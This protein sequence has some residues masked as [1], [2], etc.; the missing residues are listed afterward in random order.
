MDSALDLKNL[1]AVLY[2][3]ITAPAGVDDG[4]ATEKTLPP[5]GL[6]AIIVGDDRLSAR[7]RVEIYAN[8]YFYR[9][10]DAFKEDFPATLAV[11]GE[12]DFHNLVTGYLIDHPP[13][14][15]EIQHAG[16][17]LPDFI[18]TRPLSERW[19][20]IADLAHL[21][22]AMIEVFHAPD[23]EPLDAAMMRMVA[24]EEWG[25]IRLRTHPSLRILDLGWRADMVRRVVES[26]E[27]WKEPERGAVVILVWRRGSQVHYRELERGESAA[28]ALAQ[29]GATFAAMCDAIAA[30]AGDE[31]ENGPALISRLLDR[32]LGD[33]VLVRGN[34]WPAPPDAAS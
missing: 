29:S 27:P 14:E 10:L 34:S 6:D 33:G 19:P 12:T 16:R 9:L 8:A 15:P 5:G 21:E 1:Q 11:I 25:A 30:E 24:P 31:D 2:R 4:L 3:L 26:G 23:A 13:T 20:F 32:W 18:R 7:E 22:R 17:H 28:L